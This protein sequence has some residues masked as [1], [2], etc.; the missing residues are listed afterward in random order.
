VPWREAGADARAGE[1]C[2]DGGGIGAGGAGVEA[3]SAWASSKSAN[4]PDGPADAL[5]SG[6]LGNGRIG[7]MALVSDATLATARPFGCVP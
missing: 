2:T 3:G 4:A 5:A 6:R 1:T 7:W